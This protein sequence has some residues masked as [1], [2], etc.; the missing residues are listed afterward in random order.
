MDDF[1]KALF[2]LWQDGSNTVL[3]TS[4]RIYRIVEGVLKAAAS[5]VGLGVDFGKIASQFT[6]AQADP[7]DPA[8]QSVI[9]DCTIENSA[10]ARLCR[11]PDVRENSG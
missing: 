10:L 11:E 7:D 4:L 9:L 5:N 1:C 6:G 2:R 3:E 8:L